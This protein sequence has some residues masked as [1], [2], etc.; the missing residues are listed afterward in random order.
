MSTDIEIGLYAVR[1]FRLC[2]TEDA[3][4]LCSVSPRF[5]TGWED[6]TC[7]AQCDPPGYSLPSGIRGLVQKRHP[8]PNERCMCGI[9][10][11]F[12]YDDLLRQFRAEASQIVAVIAAEGIT[13]IGT[14]GL[15]T[16][17]ARVVAHW[18]D[19]DTIHHHVA[20]EQFKDAAAFKTPIDMMMAYDI[21]REAA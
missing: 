13:I 9:Y 16:Q 12:S 6:G 18:T 21:D 11:S 19:P 14:R 17:Y 20:A 7:E 2:G 5:S 10:G 8:A 15:R 1:T 4:K 3:P